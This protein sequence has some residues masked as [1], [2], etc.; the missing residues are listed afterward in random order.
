[1]SQTT[2]SPSTSAQAS[3]ALALR[4]TGA[5]VAESA[6]ADANGIERYTATA[7]VTADAATVLAEG[8]V[9]SSSVTGSG[10]LSAEQVTTQAEGQVLADITGTAAVAAREATMAASG[11][12]GVDVLPDLR[13]AGGGG[14]IVRIVSG[15]AA[16][17][18][19]PAEV[20]ARG[21]V[22]DDDLVLL[23]VA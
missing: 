5:V 21:S 22:N 23:L 17:T 4:A 1:M 7:T 15:R 16:A 8:S 2:D 20:F 13:P 12:G 18:A 6:T 9:A 11:I 10:A 14:R 19:R 3:G